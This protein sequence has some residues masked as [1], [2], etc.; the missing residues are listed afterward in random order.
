M[1][2]LIMGAPGSG[3]GT[4]SELLVQKLNIPAISTGVMLR[5]AI[6]EG[7]SLGK[8]A[9]KYINDGKLV[10]DDIIIGVVLERLS[11][12]DMESGYILDGFPRTLAQAEAMTEAG[13]EIDIALFIDVSDEEIMQRLGGR[14]VCSCGASY[15]IDYRPSTKG[16]FCE[17][18]GKALYIRDDDKP[19]TIA[20]RLEV[21]HKVTEPVVEYYKKK[22][23]LIAVKAGGSV[24]D[25]TAKVQ[26]AISR[27]LR[28][29]G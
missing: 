11:D 28:Y 8:Q 17:M 6:S 25:T 22:G 23:K 3:K 29:Y 21:Y 1:K 26:A 19:E 18:C 15:H 10:P 13:I 5:N 16:E 14:R 7:T 4:Q 2:M 20:S 9:E 12:K 27:S 24:E